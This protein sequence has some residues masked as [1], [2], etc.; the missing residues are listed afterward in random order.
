MSFAAHEMIE[1][2]SMHFTKQV[3]QNEPFIKVA[4]TV[5]Q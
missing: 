3:L 5:L 2:L 4:A 1:I